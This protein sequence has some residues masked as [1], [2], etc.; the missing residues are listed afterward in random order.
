MLASTRE[1][2]PAPRVISA[3]PRPSD[4]GHEALRTELDA[5]NEELRELRSTDHALRAYFASW[6]ALVSLSV[7][8]KLIFDFFNPPD[9]R[10][11]RPPYFTATPL[12]L[13]GLW[14]V[15]DALK[16]RAQKAALEKHEAVRLARQH[17]LRELL[18]L[19]EAPVPS[20]DDDAAPAVG[21]A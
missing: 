5:L 17:E 20:L 10:V 7:T 2:S 4:S 12:L 21:L 14:L 1:A 6:G 19:N 11:V 15:F 18:G 13:I 9:G 16:N 3:P 8:G